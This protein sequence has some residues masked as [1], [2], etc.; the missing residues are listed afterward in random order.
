MGIS[1][2]IVL[3]LLNALH[4]V[5]LIKERKKLDPLVRGDASYAHAALDEAVR[6]T[7]LNP[8]QTAEEADELFLKIQRNECA[9]HDSSAPDSPV[10]MT[11][12]LISEYL[13]K[14]AEESGSEDVFVEMNRF[15]V[16]LFRVRYAGRLVINEGTP[17]E[18]VI[19]PSC[20]DDKELPVYTWVRS[21]GRHPPGD[22]ADAAQ[23]YL[24]WSREAIG[25]FRKKLGLFQH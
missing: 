7:G 13:K 3:K 14:A 6:R 18:R 23:M 21:N 4:Y 17:E 12:D 9:P 10:V 16:W 8:G 19:E 5:R 15:N 25:G 20:D 1:K 22:L 11:V 24:D 2:E